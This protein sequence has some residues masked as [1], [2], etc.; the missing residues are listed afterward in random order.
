M[1][2]VRI[3]ANPTICSEFFPLCL[4]IVLSYFHI[5]FANFSFMSTVTGYVTTV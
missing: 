1:R 2:N 5:D 3:S 4:F